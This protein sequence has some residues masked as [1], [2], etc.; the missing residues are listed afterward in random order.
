[1]ERLFASH[2]GFKYER[3]DESGTVLRSTLRE[4][5]G[6]THYYEPFHLRAW[7]TFPDGNFYI[8]NDILNDAPSIISFLLLKT[9]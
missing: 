6:D 3:Y 7:I 5:F 4:A 2:T 8:R 1:M 9:Q